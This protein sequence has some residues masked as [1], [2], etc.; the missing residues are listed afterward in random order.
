[1]LQLL[2]ALARVLD[3]PAL[4]VVLVPQALSLLAHE[5]HPFPDLPVDPLQ[6]LALGAQLLEVER[7]L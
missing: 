2:Q 1:M 4:P 6:G 3:L 7:V 5:A